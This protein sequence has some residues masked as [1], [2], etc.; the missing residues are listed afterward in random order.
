[1]QPLCVKFLTPLC[2]RGDVCINVLLGDKVKML[3][4]IGCVVQLAACHLAI[5]TD[6]TLEMR[7]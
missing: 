3:L 1:M 6:M 7:V 2:P 5:Y 4:A